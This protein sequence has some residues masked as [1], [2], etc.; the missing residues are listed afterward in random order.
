MKKTLSELA[1]QG[2]GGEVKIIHIKKF[3]VFHLE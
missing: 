1:C 2:R 3:P